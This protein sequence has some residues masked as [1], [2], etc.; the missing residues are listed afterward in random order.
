M[1]ASFTIHLKGIG[2]GFFAF[3][4]AKKIYKAA[5]LLIIALQSLKVILPHM[6]TLFS[7]KH[8]RTQI[9]G[10]V[11]I[12]ILQF[13]C[14]Q[15]ELPSDVEG[16]I[17]ALPE[18]IDY[19]QDVKKIL[20]DK[21]FSCHGPDAQKQKA[22]L[23]L[24]LA[25]FAYEKTTESGLKAIKPGSLSRSELVHRILSNDPEYKMPTP[26]SHLELTAYEK[27]VLIK[28]I[29]QGAEYKPHWAFVTPERKDPPSPKEK[30][31][32]KN[33][34]DKFILDAQEKKQLHPAPMA[35]KQTLIRRLSFD[36]RGISPTLKEVDD[37]LRDKD[38]NA[39]ERLVDRFLSSAH[40]GE[41]MAAYWLDVA[42]FA[43]S[44][45]YLDDKHRDM[46]PWRDWVISA[47]NRNIPFD[48]FITWQMAGD[49]LPKP[50]QEQILATGFNR[51][52]KQNSEAGIIDEEFRVEY[53]TDRTNT[54]GTALMAMTLGCAKC[55]DHK[56]DPVSQKDYYS[57]FAFFNN[58]FEKGSPNYGDDKVVPGP[59]LLLTTPD[60]DRTISQ[61]QV[62]LKSLEKMEGE[63]FA[64]TEK[65]LTTASEKEIASSLAAKIRAK[66]DFDKVEK[67]ENDKGLFV[68]LANPKASA[69]FK[70]AEFGKGVSGNSIKYNV[71]TRV[72]FP[73]TQ[74]GYYERH[75][76][77]SV[78]L[79]LKI[80]EQYPLA[81]IFYSSE[82]HRY[83]YQGYDLLLRDN[84]INFRLS[85]SF[86]HDA[87]SVITK[88][89]VSI[90]QWHHVVATY[91]GSSKANGASL[92]L[93]GKKL[94]LEVEY[95]HLQ[96]NIQQ[97]YSIHKGPL[98]GVTLGEK[99]LDK[100]MPGGE[101]DDFQL[102]SG[103]L[104]QPEVEYLL[105]RKEFPLQQQKPADTLS[106]LYLTRRQLSEIK[107]SVKE[108]MVMG[109][110][111]KPRQTFVLKRGVYD[112]HG[113][114]VNPS[115]PN[116][117]LPF[118]P[119]LPKNRLGLAKWLFDEKNP[120]T[121]RVA[122][123]RL[124][125]LI[126]GKGLVAT[127]DD[128]GNQGAL[129]THPELLDYLAIQYRE[130]GWDTKAFMKYIF[131]SATYQQ[132]A[133]NEA[134]IIKADPENKYLTRNPRYRFPAEML[135]DNALQVAG[136][137][138][139]KMGGPSVYPY[140]PDGLWE[141]LSDKVWRYK[142]VLAEGEDL[143]RKSIYTVRKRTSVVPFL[144]IFDASDRSVC[145][146]KRQVSSSPMQSLAMLNDPQIVEAAR[147]VGVRMLKE[148]GQSQQEQIRF[149]NR[150]L[151]GRD[152]TSAEV[153][154]M[155][156]FCQSDEE[157]Y[158]KNPAKA[159]SLLLVGVSR[160]DTQQEA[161]LAA[162]TNLALS[163]MNTDEFLTRK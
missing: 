88:E 21:C 109:D 126:F 125:Q 79:W 36:I 129:P 48:Q 112:Q 95:D 137:L 69:N 146:V 121:A 5:Y 61:L 161:R 154:A 62:K 30:A 65:K 136:L 93:D 2:N 6:I 115:T 110:L 47:Y 83:G 120:L 111:P 116:A 152:P 96:K 92:Y 142:Y 28:W 1:L 51:N 151:I 20:S 147:W 131:M 25:S 64:Q 103:R 134:A 89:K 17:A 31:W 149:A 90:G 38:P 106:M 74:I 76:P 26:E 27:A 140:Q 3:A 87:I 4:F 119:S 81:T 42:R 145:T 52:H 37:F 12:L 113:D 158:K 23:R 133:V 156:E 150:L 105:K 13:S 45:G 163:V 75:D 39:Y 11:T 162:Y 49:L 54:L 16:Q 40:Y 130:K 155:M 33:D 58:T 15:I 9:L 97:H 50:T 19:N 59:T 72:V 70:K 7:F 148:G 91:D 118:D 53:V 56:Y 35:D 22:D 123:N 24:D 85:H 124:W 127:S 138:S 34:I 66:L 14:S 108:V 77:F 8:S 143:Y 94:S 107:D 82:N 122:V 44:H 46:T 10:F 43:D 80:P 117:I 29:D 71:E 160:T 101:L 102:F 144:Q 78:S 84:R 63:A 55:H 98:S 141:E 60:Q 73:A 67:K 132:Q 104:S 157:G 86:P 32:V 68:N 153:K 41:R 135:R 99:A 128:F 159:K 114:K 100:S 57:L 139:A 18:E